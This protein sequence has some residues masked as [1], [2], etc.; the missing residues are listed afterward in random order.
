MN[1][2]KYSYFNFRTKGYAVSLI[3]LLFVLTLLLNSCTK[4]PFCNCFKSAGSEVTEKRNLTEFTY[5]LVQKNVEVL[6]VQDSANYAKVT[7]GNHLVDGIVTE[8]KDG[9]LY[10]TNSNR[11]NWGRSYKN[12]F[13]VEVHCKN[14]I[15]IEYAAA[16]DLKMLNQFKLDSLYFESTDGSGSVLL[17]LDAR[18]LY[19]VLNTAV[20]DLAVTGTIKVNYFFA[21]A[22]GFF[23]ASELNADYVYMR[24][25]TANYCKV[26]SKN[27]LD[28]EIEATGN[29]Y[30][31]GVPQ[32]LNLKQVGSGKL[33]KSQ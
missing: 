26:N 30:Y 18:C 16:G 7:C 3:A 8:V 33:I 15:N 29:I 9:K 6:L 22:Q 32:I 4:E 19:A 17:N 20:A 14:L 5:L 24:S 21:N 1:Y 13:V 31:T 12:Q 25:N 23:D 27:Q 10:I 28:A 2:L 11:C